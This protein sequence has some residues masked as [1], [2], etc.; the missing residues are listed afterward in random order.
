MPAFGTANDL[1][2]AHII[3]ATTGVTPANPVMDRLRVAGETL[4][5]RIMYDEAAEINPLYAL[6]DL[7][8]VGSEAGGAFPYDFA[9]SAAMDDIMQAVLRGT[10]TA[11]VLKGG[12]VKR[13][14]TLEKSVLAGTG[15]RKYMKFPG[16]RYMGFSLTGSVGS[17]MTGSVDV[18]SLSGIPSGASVVGTGSV[19]EPADN[20]ILSMVDIS[21]LSMTGDVTP[22][23]ARGFTL[24]VN[25][26][27]RYQQ[28]HGQLASFDIA[29]GMREVTFSID[30]YF[31]SW[32]QMDKLLNRSNSN[33]QMT[34]GDGT[35][36]YVIR[37]PRL[38]YRTLDANATG[39]N[40]DLIQTIEGRGLY[41]PTVGVV[42]D[43]MITRTPA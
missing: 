42:T 37:L 43:I 21:A 5:P 24:S 1:L 26:N 34:L 39:N 33:L 17:R 4:G 30:A 6:A 14:Y 29:Y 10:W 35:N 20:R 15:G 18:M 23:I 13:S 32:E 3:E 41:D 7:V 25:N 36:S 27:G 9:K 40:A 38:R 2:L 16:S 28:G 12:T 8:G 22:L 19:T 11:G 31:E